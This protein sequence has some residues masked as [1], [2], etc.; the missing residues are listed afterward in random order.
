MCQK[1]K[2]QNVS[3]RKS[4]LGLVN[5][6]AR[7]M[8]DLATVA[9]QLRRLTKK[10][11]A[12]IFG[13]DQQGELKRRWVQAETQRYF[14]RNAKMNV[15]TN[16]SPVGLGAILVQKHKGKNRVICFASWGVSNVE[17]DYSQKKEA[18]GIVWA[19]EKIRVYFY[20]TEF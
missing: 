18:L 1:V 12:L 4:F 20:G 15:I 14:D 19:R 7:Y 16:A 9:E 8:P 13:P 10:E 11:E 2:C 5:F 17:Q 3:E 6:N